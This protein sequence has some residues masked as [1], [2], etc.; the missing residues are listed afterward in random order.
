MDSER[1][2]P[3]AEATD[4]AVASASGSFDF[5]RVFL[6]GTWEREIHSSI[7]ICMIEHL[8]VSISRP[9]RLSG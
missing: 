8:G 7:T 9:N 3:E 6:E 2:E 5:A 1:D 4:C